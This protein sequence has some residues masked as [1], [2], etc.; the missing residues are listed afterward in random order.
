MLVFAAKWM[1]EMLGHPKY[2]RRS[3]K[4]G[5]FDGSFR[6]IGMLEVFGD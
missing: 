1:A 2:T 3:T 5:L 6:I 4:L